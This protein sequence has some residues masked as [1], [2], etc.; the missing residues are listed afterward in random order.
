VI[1]LGELVRVVWND[2]HGSAANV[3]YDI[4]EIPHGPIECT[5]YGILL[6]SDEL[7]VSIASEQVGV[8][9]Y[10]GYSFMPAGM[11]VKVEQ[12]K[13]PRKPRKPK[14]PPETTNPTN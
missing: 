10:R 12:V 3:V 7:G 5:S 13:K 9:T 14:P 1:A 2:A 11:L 8:D 6:K 4:D